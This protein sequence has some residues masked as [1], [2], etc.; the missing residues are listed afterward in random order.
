MATKRHKRLRRAGQ[1]TP[2]T[3]AWR[4]SIWGLAAVI[5]FGAFVNIL[6]FAMPLY[7]LQVLD[8]IPASRST[9]TL[10]LLT[11]M[12]V[13]AVAAGFTLDVFRRR[14]LSRWGYWSVRRVGPVI[15]RRG[16]AEGAATGDFDVDRGLSDLTKVRIFVSKSLVGWLDL[17][18][19]PVFMLGVYLIHPYLGIM[20]LAAVLLVVLLGV[21]QELL[22]SEPRRASGQ[23]YR[24]AETIVSTA[25]RNRESVGAFGMSDSLASRWN[26]TARGRLAERERLDDLWHLFRTVAR[27]LSQFLRIGMIGL[28]MWLVLRGELTLGAIFAAR[29]IAGFGFVLVE[30]A[31]RS[32]RSLTEAQRAYLNLR[33]VLEAAPTAA[34]DVHPG[35]YQAA[36]RIDEVTHRHPRQRKD[37]FKRLS[38]TVK[39]GEMLLVSGAG[40]TG[41][42]TLSRLLVGLAPPRFGKVFLGDTEVAT[43]SSEDRARLIGFLPQHTE[44]FAGTVRENIARMGEGSI[45]EVVKAAQLAGIHDF[46]LGLPEG[47]DTKL[48]PDTFDQ[49]SGSQ[50][51][52][53]AIARAFYSSPRLV[54]MDEPSANLD[55]PSRRIM[56]AGL[57]QLKEAGSIVVVTQSVRSSQL[58]RMADKHLELE[59]G[60][61]DY[62][63]A[64]SASA[65]RKG[66]S[67]LRSVK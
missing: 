41:K 33:T 42:T 17:I 7:L 25:A 10:L 4:A 32:Y 30:N 34:P 43:L 2:I 1:E 44:I 46:I 13:V 23:A 48:I 60:R 40:G 26:E 20:A 39:P 3:A 66:K 16:L 22:S 37:L 55:S 19:V 28:G 21:V 8:R 52:R 27:A 29:I 24:E 36:L 12:A 63:E 15:V 57:R 56:E 38:L 6:K 67:G 51:K 50:R 65:R 11:V 54:L 58:E 62:T 64:G 53:I 5:F 61:F 45:V 18:W 9:E 14:M 47:Y 35:T 49:L 59:D 31:V